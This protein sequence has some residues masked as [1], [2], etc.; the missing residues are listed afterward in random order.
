MLLGIGVGE[1][2]GVVREFFSYSVGAVVGKDLLGGA[3]CIA[4]HRESGADLLELGNLVGHGED[5]AYHYGGLGVD[6]GA[7]NED[8]GEILGHAARDVAV[9][10]VAEG[11]EFA[12]AAAGVVTD[13]RELFQQE[14]SARGEFA[15]AVGFFE[16]LH[17]AVVFLI[18]E[19]PA[20]AVA[21]VML[22][23]EGDVAFGRVGEAWQAVGR[24]GVGKILTARLIGVDETGL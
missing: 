16:I 7:G 12:Y 17:G 22:D 18:V 13:F 11:S 23:V 6:V 3:G 15:I 2:L 14:F 24:T 4:C 19:K 21:S 20:A 1:V 9:L 8:F 5:A 10:P